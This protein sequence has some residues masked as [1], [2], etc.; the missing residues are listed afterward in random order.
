MCQV[1][2]NRDIVNLAAMQDV[3]DSLFADMAN[4]THLF[5]GYILR[6][7]FENL[8]KAFRQLHRFH[9]FFIKFQ[10][11]V[12]SLVDNVFYSIL[13]RDFSPN[14]LFFPKK[15]QNHFWL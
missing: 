10:R 3:I 15:R 13:D 4:L 6:I 2:D 8:V 7:L 11:Q 14:S 12:K 5:F 9:F 1:T